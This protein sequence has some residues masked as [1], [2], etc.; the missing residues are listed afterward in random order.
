MYHNYDFDDVNEALPRLL[1]DLEKKGDEVSSRAGATKEL[2]HVGITLRKPWNREIILEH[3]KPNLA[4]QIAETVWVLAGHNDIGWLGHY[5]PRAKDFSD[6]GTTWRA[7]YGRRLRAWPRRD[8]SSDVVDQWRWAVDHL[9][10]SRA[11]RQAVMSIWDPV[12]DTAPGKDIPCNDWLNFSSR[13]G[14]LDL[15]VAL[16]SNDVIWGWSGI[17][18]FEW[19]ALLEV[20]A[21]LLGVEVGSLHFS[22]TSFHIYDHHWAKGRRVAE[23]AFS[24]WPVEPALE[25]PRFRVEAGHRYHSDFEWFEQCLEDFLAIEEQIR[26]GEDMDQAVDNFREPML[27]SWLRVLQWWWT[28]DRDHLHPLLGTRL[29]QASHFSVQPPE[30]EFVTLMADDR[31]VAR[32]RVDLR[33]A[34]DQSDFLTSLCALHLEKEAAYGGSWKKRGEMLGIMAN[35]ARKID[36]LEGGETADETSAD[37]AGDL[38]VYLAK[39]HTWLYEHVVGGQDLVG[40]SDSAENA[41]QVMRQVEQE[42]VAEPWPA[43]DPKQIAYLSEYLVK[44]FDRL[45]D[46]V[47]RGDTLRHEI[48]YDMM[49]E[50]YVLARTLWERE[51]GE[52]EYRG[53]DAD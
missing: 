19:S 5:L 41:N 20:T 27:Q 48:V 11:S 38:L 10:G 32:R 39:Y 44:T 30:R 49:G 3:R 7:G 18:Q 43:G 33:P 51:Q 52:D 35:I 47:T 29:E 4:A 21:G 40:L 50:A 36:R 24:A 1:M 22:T 9:K 31:P 23:H 13:L 16:R 26:H 25:S 46:A 2:T 34:F 14:R 37:T 53:A 28:G 42:K 8:G 17:N 12:I 45:E 6:D 15:H